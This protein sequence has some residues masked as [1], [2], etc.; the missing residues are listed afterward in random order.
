MVE[1]LLVRHGETVFNVQA[2]IQGMANSELT[3]AGVN[4][5]Q[6]LGRGMRLA[7]VRVAAAYSSDLTRAFDTANYALAAAG[8][9]LTVH[10]RP[11]LRE[12]NYGKYEGEP[13]TALTQGVFHLPTLAAV[14]ARYSLID[15]ANLTNAA[16]R[17]QTPNE[18]ETAL[19]V[20]ARF[21]TTMR[22][23]AETAA[24]ADQARVLVV[25]HGASILLWLA[26][27][28]FDIGNLTAVGNASVTT[29]S[30]EQATFHVQDVNSLAWVH[31]GATA[32]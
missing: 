30:Y 20:A 10:K 17:D 24:V 11:G 21:D 27:I 23:I 6:A 2:R 15:L 12:E 26:A 22:D 16:N 14:M 32:K 9:A 3:P 8:N 18:A 29:L 28:G 7:G 25:A 31:A 1:I 13:T 4:M 5:A 19:Q